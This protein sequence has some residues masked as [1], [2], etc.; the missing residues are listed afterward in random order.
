[1][2]YFLVL[3]SWLSA[4]EECRAYHGG[5]SGNANVADYALA[6]ALFRP[7]LTAGQKIQS[8]SRVHASGL[9][10]PNNGRTL[11]STNI[12]ELSEVDEGGLGS[13]IKLPFTRISP[14]QPRKVKRNR[15]YW[16]SA[17]AINLYPKPGEV[18]PHN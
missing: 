10:S 12:P 6:R 13:G 5:K 17:E 8:H 1:M 15:Y 11:P 2:D 16:T 7:Y 9:T 4:I 18:R 14:K 3:S